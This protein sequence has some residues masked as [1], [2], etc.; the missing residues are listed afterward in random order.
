M[1]SIAILL[2]LQQLFL[3]YIPTL[4]QQKMYQ[5]NQVLKM[6]RKGLKP[7]DYARL[8]TA[9]S[10]QIY[11]LLSGEFLL[12]KGGIYSFRKGFYAYI[13]SL[14]C[15]FCLF[16]SVF[17]LPK[18]LVYLVPSARENW[19]KLKSFSSQLYKKLKKAL[20]RGIR[21]LH[22]HATTQYVPYYCLYDQFV[23]MVVLL[24]SM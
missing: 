6:T 10:Y 1:L 23:I 15:L 12:I 19:R 24:K 8:R 13:P 9:L 3:R 22:L 17:I 14:A 2:S 20:G 4:S 16:D 5:L 7:W 18:S 21:M 11:I